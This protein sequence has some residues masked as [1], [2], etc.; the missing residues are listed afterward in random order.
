MKQGLY[1]ETTYN[2]IEESFSQPSFGFIPSQ[3][4]ENS[5]TFNRS[6]DLPS[7]PERLRLIAEC[8][9]YG[10]IL[11][12]SVRRLHHSEEDCKANPEFIGKIERYLVDSFSDTKVYF[13]MLVCFQHQLDPQTNK[14]TSWGYNMNEL[15]LINPQPLVFDTEDFIG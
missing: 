12:A 6:S 10:F 15:V 5:Y 11:G 14:P 7:I 8:K 13:P 4:R 2:G 9:R 1:A 3:S